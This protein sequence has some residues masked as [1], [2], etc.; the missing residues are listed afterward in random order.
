MGEKSLFITNFNIAHG[1]K[2]CSA[3]CVGSR[4]LC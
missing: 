4:M 1:S 2:F 3:F